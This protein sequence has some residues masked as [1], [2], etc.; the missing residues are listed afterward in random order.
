MKYKLIGLSTVIP[1]L[2]CAIFAQKAEPA[3]NRY[4]QHLESLPKEA[5]TDHGDETFCTHLPLM[6][7]TT[8]APMPDPYLYDEN[9]NRLYNEKGSSLKND[10]MVSASVQ[11]FDSQTKNNH[12]TDDPAV[13]SRAL[14]RVR[15]NSSRSFDKFNYLVKFKQDD[16]IENLNVSLSGMTADN[17]WV[18]HGPFLDKSLIR[19]YLCYNLSGEI[20]DYAPNVRFCELFINGEFMGIYLIVEKIDYNKNGRLDITKTDPDLATT[21]YILRADRGADDPNYALHTF[22]NHAYITASPNERSCQLEIIYPASTLTEQQQQFIESDFSRFEKSLFSFDYNDPQKGYTRY[23]DTDSFVDYFL[24]N[25]FT[26]NYDAVDLSTYL[27]KDIGSLL[28]MCVWDFNSAFDYYM[29]SY[30][31]P[32]TFML[33]N[34]LW[35]KYLF[36][37]EA[38]VDQVIERYQYLRKTFFNEDYLFEYIDGVV[39]YLGPAI[40]RNFEKWGYSFNSTYNGNDY[41]YLTP[42]ERNVRSH[43]EAVVQIKETISQRIIFMDQNLDRL[44]SLCH[45]SVNKKYTHSKEE[46][47]G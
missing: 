46:N 31:N 8:D 28:K 2:I 20:M 7:I 23:I 9:G 12:L 24:I 16:M 19:N 42:A 13:N 29:N 14:I 45:E 34:R 3:K 6:N 27:Y 36:K 22:A 30:T 26:I 35:Y 1:L 10:E 39:D 38:F 33:H 40:D 11:Y 32:Q 18:L 15:G 17:S 43:E 41:D 25:E 37:D 47:F 44:Y 5:C 21:S 4:H